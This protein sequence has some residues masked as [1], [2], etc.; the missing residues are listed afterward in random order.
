M[1]G[2]GVYGSNYECYVLLIMV[3]LIHANGFLNGSIL[4]SNYPC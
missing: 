3:P 4:V 2:F 1:Q